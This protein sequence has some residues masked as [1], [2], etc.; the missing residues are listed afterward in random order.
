[1]QAKR[2]GLKLLPG[3][4]VFDLIYNPAPT[5]LLRQAVAAGLRTLDGRPMY[6]R[7]AELQFAA[8][9]DGAAMPGPDELD[10]V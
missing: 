7:Q 6:R 8:W 1:D 4:L 5:K 3:C 9:H 10:E 2:Q